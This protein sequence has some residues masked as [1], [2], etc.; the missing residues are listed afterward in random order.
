MDRFAK[1]MISLKQ[2]LD[3]T[4]ESHGIDKR[5]QQESAVV[6]WEDIVGAKIAQASKAVKIDRGTLLI[7]VKSCAWKQQ[8]QML[9][10]EIIKKLNAQLG[11]DVVKDIRFR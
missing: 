7:E 10:P 9:K 4:L 3:K 5:L 8:I 1:G 6:Q 2:I 11:A